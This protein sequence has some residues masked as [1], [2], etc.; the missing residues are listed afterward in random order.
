M[1]PMAIIIS[2]TNFC[3]AQSSR[4]GFNVVSPVIGIVDGNE[5]IICTNEREPFARYYRWVQ[6]RETDCTGLLVMPEPITK[7]NT[8]FGWV[9]RSLE[10]WPRLDN[11]ME[12]RRIYI[13]N[14]IS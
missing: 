6:W 10:S 7:L 3:A 5:A 8:K 13:Y 11:R 2:K 4:G 1:I 12:K 14:S 9:C